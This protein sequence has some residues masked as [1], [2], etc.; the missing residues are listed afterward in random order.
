MLS[1]LV[2]KNTIA[3]DFGEYECSVDN[4][5]GK[6]S[7]TVR[8]LRL[9]NEIEPRTWLN[10][11][12]LDDSSL[13]LMVL[14]SVTVGVLVVLAILLIIIQCWRFRGKI[15]KL[16]KKLQK[17]S[18]DD[19]DSQTDSDYSSYTGDDDI[20]D[21]ID[22]EEENDGM[23]EST[24]F[25]DM[26]PYRHENFNPENISMRAAQPVLNSWVPTFPAPPPLS[27]YRQDNYPSGDIPM[28]VPQPQFD[29]RVHLSP[30]PPPVVPTKYQFPSFLSDLRARRAPPP[31][32]PPRSHNP[33]Q[34]Y[35]EEPQD[36][37]QAARGTFVSLV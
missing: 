9:G 14:V 24:I 21:D 28:R 17:D 4:G 25:S 33:S 29:T 19:R 30:T 36:T 6:D 18:S 10:L 35:F 31:L 5:F 32:P 2:I 1:T 16:R 13:V 27:A 8:L 12:C 7:L 20:V 34:Q 37:R 11:I 15:K 22:N 3:T 26:T 23:E